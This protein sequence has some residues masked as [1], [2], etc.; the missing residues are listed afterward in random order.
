[1]NSS[2]SRRKLRTMASSFSLPQNTLSNI[3]SRLRIRSV[4]Q[5]KSLSNDWAY[6]TSTTTFVDDHLRCSSSDLSHP[7]LLQYP[8]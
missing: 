5:F 8:V 2:C 7:P 3:L 4:T 6:L 1:M